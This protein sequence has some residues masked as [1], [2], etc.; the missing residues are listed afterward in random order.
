MGVHWE[1]HNFMMVKILI[2]KFLF[3]NIFWLE[4]SGTEAAE[5]RLSVTHR[6]RYALKENSRW[7]A[8]QNWSYEN[9]KSNLW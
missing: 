1:F 6:T 2:W 5:S 8:N 9:A 3:Q 4:T 7:D